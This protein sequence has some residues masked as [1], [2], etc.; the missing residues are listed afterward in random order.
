MSATR[1]ERI[2]RQNQVTAT[3]ADRVRAVLDEHTGV[4]FTKG[5]LC[6]LAGIPE[7]SMGAVVLFLRKNAT[8]IGATIGVLHLGG[9]WL[10]GWAELIEEHSNEQL[11][12]RQNAARAAAIDVETLT[13]SLREHPGNVTFQRQLLSAKHRLEDLEMQ[14]E[15]L[16]GQLRLIRSQIT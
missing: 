2:G 3:Y 4:I 8:E 15:E 13:Q 11:K 10:Y 1:Q 12:R 6:E 7:S 16:T 5:R 9:E 14:K